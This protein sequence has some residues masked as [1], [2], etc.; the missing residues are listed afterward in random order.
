MSVKSTLHMSFVA[1]ALAVGTFAAATA[2]GS[3]QAEAKMGGG[4]GAKTGSMYV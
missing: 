1:A 4:G 2:I 3:T